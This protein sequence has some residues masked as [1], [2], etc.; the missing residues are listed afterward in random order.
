MGEQV[1]AGLFNIFC[2]A[3]REGKGLHFLMALQKAD[4]SKESDGCHVVGAS[5]KLAE[6]ASSQA[7][8]AMRTSTAMGTLKTE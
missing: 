3:M 6:Q 2:R 1:A 5:G 8:F 7:Q 4:N